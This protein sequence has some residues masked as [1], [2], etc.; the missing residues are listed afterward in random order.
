M[1]VVRVP[2]GDDV[3][4]HDLATRDD[5]S[6]AQGLLTVDVMPWA[7]AFTGGVSGADVVV[8]GR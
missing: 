1:T 5:L 6:V 8:R 4:V 7:V 2:A 3:D